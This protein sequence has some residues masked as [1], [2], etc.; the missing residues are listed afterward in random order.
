MVTSFT[1]GKVTYFSYS[2]RG[3]EVVGWGEEEVGDDEEV[4]GWGEEE[5]GWGEEEVGDDEEVVVVGEEELIS[6][7]KSDNLFKDTA[8]RVNILN[9]L[10]V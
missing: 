3:E 8:N 10:S 1:L 5:V 7:M 6:V 2:S 9:S 4:V